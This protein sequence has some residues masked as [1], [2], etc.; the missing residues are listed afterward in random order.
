MKIL[1]A[2]LL[3]ASCIEAHELNV[4]NGYRSDSLYRISTLERQTDTIHIFD[5]PLWQVGINGRY[6]PACM[7]VFLSGFAYWGIGSSGRFTEM[8]SNGLFVQKGKAVL[9]SASTCDYQI[10]IGGF[11]R[12]LA[13]SAGYAYDRQRIETKSGQIAFPYP[14]TV[15]AN[16]PIYR[17]GYSTTTAWS[18]PWIGLDLSKCWRGWNFR[19]GYE[20]HLPRYVAQHNIPLNATAQL[21][22]FANR[23]HSW[24]FGNVLF[25]DG[26][27]CLRDGW[28]IGMA[29]KY[30]NWK[31][32][33]GLLRT[34]YFAA[35]GYPPGTTAHS[36][37]KWISYQ[38]S[39]DVGYTF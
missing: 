25:V 31:S 7:P 5:I 30:Q 19:G 16:A 34:G 2:G 4:R 11:Y 8:I 26:Y 17:S 20:F 36:R 13:I 14:Y 3:F 15:F 18:G 9:R 35:N 23:T 21:Q 12:W 32:N 22:G 39:L 27:T 1:F 37:G 10:G 29:F 33:R 28:Q 38:F 6:T 24:G